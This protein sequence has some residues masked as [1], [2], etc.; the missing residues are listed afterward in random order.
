[1]AIIRFSSTTKDA[2]LTPVQAAVDG[3]TGA[4]LIRI[5]TT[6]MPATP[7]T[8][9]TTQ[10]LLGTLTFSDPCGTVTSGTLTM[11]AVTQD[12]A[13]D[14]TGTAVWARILN[15]SGTAIFDVDVTNTGGGGTMQMNT[16]NI[17][18]GGPILCTAFTMTVS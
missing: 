1:M 15:S 10:T 11:S 12:A 5:Y 9:I 4:G 17:V 13:A 14:A 6:P 2:I 7:E 16:T 8:A 18:V 3:G